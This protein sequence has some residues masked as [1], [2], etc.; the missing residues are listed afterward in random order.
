MEKTIIE[1]LSLF[2]SLFQ[3]RDEIFAIHWE[4]GNKSDYFPVYDYDPYQYRL[5]KIKGGTINVENFVT[6]HALHA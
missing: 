2:K 3:G 5:H 1:N 4:K 6:R